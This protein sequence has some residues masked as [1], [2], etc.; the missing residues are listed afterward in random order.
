[1]RYGRSWGTSYWMRFAQQPK[2]NNLR[3][4]RRSQ[5]CVG[6]EK[7]HH[8][9][10]LAAPPLYSG[11]TSGRTPADHNM[12]ARGMGAQRSIIGG[13]VLYVHSCARHTLRALTPVAI[14]L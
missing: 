11:K 13:I 10:R 2:E 1:M 6:S 5:S 8:S 9:L 4:T 12:T 7:T 3:E 14:A